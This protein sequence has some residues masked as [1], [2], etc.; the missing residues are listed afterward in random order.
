M[1]LGSSSAAPVIRP[2][3]G[4]WNNFRRSGCLVS[5]SAMSPILI[6]VRGTAPALR[7]TL[8]AQCQAPQGPL[9]GVW[10][11]IASLT[12][13]LVPRSPDDDRI[14]APTA[15]TVIAAA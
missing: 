11:L 14:L 1:P 15:V 8:Q 6:G 9:P 12:E 10:S 3:P 4:I 2:G 7:R 13:T 5:S